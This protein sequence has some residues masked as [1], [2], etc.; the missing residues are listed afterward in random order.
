M[1]IRMYDNLARRAILAALS[2]DWQTALETNLTILTEETEDIGA[3]NRTARAYLQL[4]DLENAN[5]YSQKVL[6]IDPL[7]PIADKCL[8]RCGLLQSN[9]TYIGK[10]AQTYD[11]FLE[12][13][14]KTKIVSLINICEPSILA[15]LD[16][17]YNVDLVAKTRRV[18][19]TTPAEVYIG[20]LPDDLATRIIYFIKNGNEYNSFIKS[21]SESDVK[22]FIKETKRAEGLSRVPSF[23]ARR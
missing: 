2:S 14:G 12:V 20:R 16:A 22:V 23:P 3:L 10:G 5:L 9:K 19:V 6:V 11:I 21:I 15:Q 8:T 4:G 7:N 17:G 18:V 13:P 1:I